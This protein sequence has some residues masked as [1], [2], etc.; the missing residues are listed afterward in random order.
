MIPPRLN[1]CA[2]ICTIWFMT[3]ITI[4]NHVKLCTKL[5]TCNWKCL[6]AFPKCLSQ[7]LREA[8]TNITLRNGRP[9]LSWISVP[10]YIRKETIISSFQ[11]LREKK[12]WEKWDFNSL[13]GFCVF[14]I[15]IPGVV[16]GI[17][18]LSFSSF[19]NIDPHLERVIIQQTCVVL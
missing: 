10:S 1:L 15:I 5:L 3:N 11:S 13:L 6:S 14:W 18:Y 9:H 12:L 16:W 19:V 4:K 8:F 17:L 2:W 7:H